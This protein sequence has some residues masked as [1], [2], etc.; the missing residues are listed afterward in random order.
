MKPRIAFIGDLPVAGVLPEECL[1][2]SH[3]GSKHP[4]PWVAA[5]LPALARLSNFQLRVLLVH[6]AIVKATV[7][8][9]N[10]VEYEAVPTQWLER[11]NRPTGYWT[12]SLATRA[13]LRRFRPHLVHAFGFETGAAT[14]ALRSGF[15]VSCFIQ[16]IAEFLFKVSTHMPVY[17]RR[18]ARAAEARAITQVRWLVAETEFARRWALAKNPQAQ[19]TLIPH[20]LRE[21]FLEQPAPAFGERLI[22]V[23]SLIFTKGMDTVLRAFAQTRRPGARL[24][25]VG[26]GALRG[27]LTRLAAE[28]GL[29]SRVDFLG[30]LGAEGVIQQM[31]Q[32]S[33]CVLG[34]RM[35]TSPNVLTEAHALGLPVIGTRTGGIP[36]MIEDGKD[37]FVV[38]V[39]DLAGMAARMDELLGSAELATRLGAAGREKVSRLNAAEAVA[40][41]HRDFF[42]RILAQVS[43]HGAV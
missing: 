21:V 32:C 24:A 36:E 11:W 14:I 40:T 26:D 5:L 2:A 29:A 17:H 1:R 39:D 35:D 6:R 37:G 7:V 9:V 3:R 23:G 43:P 38:G 18:I 42:G 10:G 22:T 12:K 19:V 8:E 4:A 27:D 31:L 28:L 20:P 16:G 30:S 15:P 25:V 34:S 13:A 41:A 33:A